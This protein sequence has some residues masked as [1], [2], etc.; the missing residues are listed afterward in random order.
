[1]KTVQDKRSPE[2]WETNMEHLDDNPY[3]THEHISMLLPWYVNKTLSGTELNE[4]KQHLKVCLICKREI[5]NLRHLSAAVNQADAF[6]SPVQ[7][8]FAHLKKRLHTT[9][10][11]ATADNYDQ[12]SPS[13]RFLSRYQACRKINLNCFKMPRVALALA[14]MMFFVLLLPR[15]FY[16]NPDLNHQYRT[17][18][19]TENS[20][21]NKNELSVIFRDGTSQQTIHQILETIQ[22]QIVNGPDE[23]SLYTVAINK[24]ADLSGL[25]AKLTLLRNNA[26]V[27]FAEP[28]YALLS[29]T[30][31]EKVSE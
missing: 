23:Q 7:V 15:F 20:I 10:D 18:S 3:A 14:A 26:Q 4:V 11:T 21:M 29:A 8:A 2:R 5:I 1:M 24:S 16:T 9:T 17:L 13:V 28:A 25:M 6:D 31:T 22:G 12:P 19:G 30:Q 27:V